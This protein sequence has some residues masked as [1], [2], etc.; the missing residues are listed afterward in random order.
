MLWLHDTKLLLYA[1]VL[2]LLCIMLWGGCQG[3]NRNAWVGQFPAHPPATMRTPG[4]DTCSRLRPIYIWSVLCKEWLELQ[5]CYR[6]MF[7]VLKL[8]CYGQRPSN[9]YNSCKCSTGKYLYSNV[10]M[11]FYISKLLFVSIWAMKWPCKKHKK[12]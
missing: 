1:V 5:V 10:I 6:Q 4:Q 9:R 12:V 3:N 2:L 11:L 8:S 7:M